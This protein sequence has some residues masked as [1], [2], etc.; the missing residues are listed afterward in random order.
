S[1]IHGAASVA[2]HA[3]GTARRE[4]KGPRWL[5]RRQASDGTVVRASDGRP[6]GELVLRLPRPLPRLL[7]GK[8]RWRPSLREGPRVLRGPRGREIP[9]HNSC[10]AARGR[11][12]SPRNAGN[13][14]DR[15]AGTGGGC[16]GCGRLRLRDRQGPGGGGRG[17]ERGIVA[18]GHGDLRD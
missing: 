16:G 7:Y 12:K 5:G 11:R 6:R 13:R 18:A 17:G 15:K 1:E 14:S 3:G 8:E 9:E 2:D 10:L 4:K